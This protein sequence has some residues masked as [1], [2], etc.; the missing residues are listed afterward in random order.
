MT[1]RWSS[2]C[3]YAVSSINTSQR[4]ATGRLTRLAVGASIRQYA[5]QQ[6]SP[7]RRQAVASIQ[8][9]SVAPTRGKSVA[10]TQGKHIAPAREK[11]IE[12]T[13][14]VNHEEYSPRAALLAVESGNQRDTVNPPLSTLPPPL[15]LPT[16][17][18]ESNVFMYLLRLGRAYGSFYKN[19]VKAVWFNRKAANML[20]AQVKERVEKHAAA[21]GGLS[22]LP[23][24]DRLLQLAA[25]MGLLTR[26]E[27]EILTR[28]DRDIGKLPVFGV[29][30]V[31]FGEWLPLI[32]PF[33]PS[34]VP[35][36]CLIPAQIKGMRVAMEER[37]KQSFRK[38]VTSFSE[39]VM[40]QMRASGPRIDGTPDQMLHMS[41][42]L[43]LHARLWDRLNIIPPKFLLQRGFD[44]RMGYIERDDKLLWTYGASRLSRQ[45]V[46]IACEMRGIDVLHRS[47]AV[48][49]EMLTW[50]LTKQQR[51]NASGAA[52]YDMLFKRFVRSIFL[53]TVPRLISIIGPVLGEC[54]RK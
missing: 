2:S 33:V 46:A 8:G 31:V 9:S 20:Q 27:S 24:K 49:R 16:R 7:A 34:V 5:S 3:L 51:D 48:L 29:M 32:V 47:D 52:F 36:T 30:V 37:R 35:G 44:R 19:G 39:A 6:H 38:G 21:K 41:T 28:H 11:P 42:T 12:V 23:T 43:G 54:R 45:E 10:P 18:N 22:E 14:T 13:P 25:R 53:A 26:A 4:H 17:A 50:W 40:K 1:S 15:D